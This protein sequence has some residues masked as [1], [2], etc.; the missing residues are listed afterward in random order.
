[1]PSGTSMR[2]RRADQVEDGLELTSVARRAFDWIGFVVVDA[3]GGLGW[4]EDG[5]LF[6]DLYSGTAGVLLGCAEA[7]AAGLCTAQVS[8]SAGEENGPGGLRF[9]G[10][11]PVFFLD[12]PARLCQ[13]AKRGPQLRCLPRRTST[14]GKMAASE[15]LRVGPLR[16]SVARKGTNVGDSRAR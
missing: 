13:R 1:M 4:L 10:F 8:A 14:L 7:A 6:D 3:D 5:V 12:V 16:S 2:W 9:A 15:G 11:L